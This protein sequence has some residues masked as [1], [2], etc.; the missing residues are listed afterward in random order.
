MADYTLSAKIT[1]DSG[2]FNKAIQ[3]AEKAASSFEKK[4]ES[5]SSKAK[6][7]GDKISGIGTALTVGVT[8]PL[9]V[10]GKS[11]VT[12]ASDF[13]ENLN[14]V[15]VAFGN[16]ADSVKSWADTATKNFGLSMNQ[17]LE[18]TSLFGDMATSMGLTQPAAASM[19]T[20]LAGLAGDLASFKNIEIDQAMT[21]L[22][23]VFTGETESLKQLGIVMT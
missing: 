12:A 16:S 15:N 10:A 1:G 6:S 2:G 9:A 7:I 8:T 19:S 17:A 18:A 21:A 4:M 5:I 20:S 22:S 3:S 14:K 13:D 11:M 23:G